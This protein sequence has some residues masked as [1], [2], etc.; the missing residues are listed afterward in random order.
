MFL[1]TE[2]FTPGEARDCSKATPYMFLAYGGS[3]HILD[4]IPLGPD[5]GKGLGEESVLMMMAFAFENYRIQTFSAKIGKSNTASLKLFRKLVSLNSRSRPITTCLSSSNLVVI[6]HG[7]WSS[8]N[9]MF[10]L[11]NLLTW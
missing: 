8:P 9:L 5:R 11:N 2:P 1:F 6:D 4:R 3:G 10:V 7:Y